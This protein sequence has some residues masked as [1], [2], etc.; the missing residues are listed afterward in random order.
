MASMGARKLLREPA[1][2]IL[3]LEEP[4]LPEELEPIPLED[5]RICRFRCDFM[6]SP[7]MPCWLLRAAADRVLEDEAVEEV[8]KLLLNKKEKN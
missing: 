5:E 4:T 2:D 6:L 8:L 1:V 3:D 7:G